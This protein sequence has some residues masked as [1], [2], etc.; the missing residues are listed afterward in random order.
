MYLIALPNICGFQWMTITV[1]EV[2]RTNAVIKSLSDLPEQDINNFFL[3]LLKGVLDLL[4]HVDFC[5][6]A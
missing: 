6:I 2:S 4:N 3:I 5:L 1:K